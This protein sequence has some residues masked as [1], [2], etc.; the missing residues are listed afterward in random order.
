M[1]CLQGRGG[2]LCSFPRIDA[3]KEDISWEKRMS[4]HPVHLSF[5]KSNI[6]FP[7]FPAN[8][9]QSIFVFFAFQ[10]NP[11]TSHPSSDLGQIKL[12]TNRLPP[13][14]TVR[15]LCYGGFILNHTFL[16]ISPM[17]YKKTYVLSRYEAGQQP[18]ILEE[19][20]YWKVFIQPPFCFSSI[21]ILMLLRWKIQTQL[22]VFISLDHRMCM[23]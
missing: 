1:H 17:G 3:K 2:N 19:K 11:K 6:C 21:S 9:S 5:Q 22:S 18:L 8:N 10:L 20:Y 16:G 15:S 12:E 4:S 13:A 7:Q 23:V 14:L